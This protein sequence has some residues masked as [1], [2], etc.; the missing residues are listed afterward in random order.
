M[1]IVGTLIVGSHKRQVV[2]ALIVRFLEHQQRNV[3]LDN[4]TSWPL[5]E[6]YEL[7][8]K[9]RSGDSGLAASPMIKSAKV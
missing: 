9:G 1:V 3:N 6:Q 7:A 8:Q 5:V 2:G 4:L